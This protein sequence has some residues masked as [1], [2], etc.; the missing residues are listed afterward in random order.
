MYDNSDQSEA[1]LVTVNT[2]TNQTLVDGYAA[3]IAARQA[4]LQDDL[5]LYTAKLG[6][7]KQL[8]PLDFTGLGKLYSSHVEHIEAL[9]GEFVD[10]GQP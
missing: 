5:G 7:L 2:A 10:D 6:D 1:R 8:D 4:Q 9:L 3:E